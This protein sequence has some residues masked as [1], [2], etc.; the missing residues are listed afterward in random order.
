[1]DPDLSKRAVAVATR[2]R[3]ED[4]IR[5]DLAKVR[6]TRQRQLTEKLVLAAVGSLPWVGAVAGALLGYKIDRR[7]S[8]TDELQSRWLE[9][10]GRRLDEL[11]QDLLTITRQL[12]KVG[13]NIDERIKSER[14]LALVRR[15]FRTW[16]RADTREKRDY[17]R[18]L[19][20]SA[21]TTRVCSDDVVRLFVDWIDA[22]DEAHFGVI[23]T[24]HERPGCTRGEIWAR[25]YGKP[26]REDSA[27]ADLFRLLVRDLTVGGV[28]RQER[29][30]T[31]DGRFVRT[32]G[33]RV[34][35]A[36]P[37][38]TLE[39]AFEATKPYRLTALGVQFVTYVMSDSG[40]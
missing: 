5:G 34:P 30:T 40:D 12:G 35:V 13:Q 4:V 1:M 36:A 7:K 9:E 24:V 8:T 32:K 17:V 16:D 15:A 29:P 19:I 39:T 14:Y 10:H 6:A 11:A 23:R 38:E 21:A 3:K 2:R 37:A 20:T 18:A 26:A 31:S 28:I 27:D 25:L 33:K 22:Y